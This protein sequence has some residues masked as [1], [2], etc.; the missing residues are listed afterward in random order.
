MTIIRYPPGPVGLPFIGHLFSYRRDPIGFLMKAI[1]NYGDIVHFRLGPRNF[2]LLNHPDHLEDVLVRHNR[3]FEKKGQT[4]PARQV[5]GTGLLYSRGDFHLRQRRLIQPAFHRQRILTY[6]EV[7]TKYSLEMQQRWQE[8]MNLDIL[9]EMTHLTLR[10]V[11][12]TLFDRDLE[13]ETGEISET[14]NLFI[15]WGLTPGPFYRL[16]EKLSLPSVHR[17]QKALNQVNTFVHKMINERRISGVDPGDVLSMLLQAQDVE[18]DGSGMTDRQ[19]RDEIMTLFITGHET[20][21]LALTWTW[22][23]LS[24]YPDVEAKLHAE[25]DTVLADRPPTASDVEQLPYT[26]MVFMEAMRLYPPTWRICRRVLE[27]YRIE[28]YLLPADSVIMIC[29]Y[30]T[31]HDSRYFPDPFKFD[32]ER[33]LPR[34]EI[35][36]PRCAYFPFGAGPRQCIGESFAWMEGILLIATLA[37]RW[38]MRLVPNHPVQIMLSVTLRPKYGM[39]IILEKRKPSLNLKL[40]DFKSNITPVP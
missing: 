7:M 33:W 37:Q 13:S 19:I 3:N 11:G 17:R 32:P 6:A 21:A 5:M 10:I 22:Y 1:R 40:T 16:L 26:R 31:H 24:Q 38:R 28:N 12:K 20:T 9:E 25:I 18:G 30:V 27:D 29:P 4:P 2:F 36:L 39:R 15:K 8:G 34:P 23:L 14:F 35:R